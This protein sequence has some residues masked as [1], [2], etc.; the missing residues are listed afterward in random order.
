MLRN[1]SLSPFLKHQRRILITTSWQLL[2]LCAEEKWSSLWQLPEHSVVIQSFRAP[3]SVQQV[4]LPS[5][6]TSSNYWWETLLQYPSHP[7][8]KARI[9]IVSH[10]FLAFL[11]N[12]NFIDTNFLTPQSDFSTRIQQEFKVCFTSDHWHLCNYL[13]SWK[14]T[15]HNLNNPLLKNKNLGEE[16]K[17]SYY[18]LSSEGKSRIH[19][20]MMK[21]KTLK[22]MFQNILQYIL[23]F[24]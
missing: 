5:Y 9:S 24:I 7:T 15:Q 2:L 14:K 4:M 3:V 23:F 19:K 11:L 13:L 21:K 6:K 16:E 10:C 1:H 8:H 22:V 20:N 18:P 12:F 17:M